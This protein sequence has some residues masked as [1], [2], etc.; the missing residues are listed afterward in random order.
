MDAVLLGFIR[1]VKLREAD[2]RLS[3]TRYS[4]VV[5]GDRSLQS[6]NVRQTR[7]GSLNYGLLLLAP[8]ARSRTIASTLI[9]LRFLSLVS[10]ASVT[11]T[12]D[13]AFNGLLIPVSIK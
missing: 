9:V 12:T 1:K 7:A 5:F 3:L 6:P 8:L 2:W 4:C 11:G 10:N 13:P